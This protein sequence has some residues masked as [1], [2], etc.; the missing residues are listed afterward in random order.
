[1]APRNDCVCVYVLGVIYLTKY[2]SSMITFVRCV[3]HCAVPPPP[4]PPFFFSFLR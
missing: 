1:M 3:H 2:W 4:P